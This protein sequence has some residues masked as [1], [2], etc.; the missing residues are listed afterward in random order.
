[1]P[2]LYR[3]PWCDARRTSLHGPSKRNHDGL[4]RSGLMIEIKI[5][6]VQLPTVGN[7]RIV[8]WKVMRIMIIIEHSESCRL[9]QA[10]L[11]PV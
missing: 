9:Q 7:Y 4:S 10:S 6:G 1:M 8:C 2:N 11:V 3:A 5:L